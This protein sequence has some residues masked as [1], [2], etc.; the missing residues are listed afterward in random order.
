MTQEARNDA[1]AKRIIDFLCTEGVSVENIV[2]TLNY[3]FSQTFIADKDVR[4]GKA[5]IRRVAEG[6]NYAP[7]IDI[8][9]QS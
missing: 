2:R 9:R 1:S 7:N 5:I 6:S 8:W 4:S 3:H